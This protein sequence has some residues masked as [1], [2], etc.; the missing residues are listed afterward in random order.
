MTAWC[1]GRWWCRDCLAHFRGGMGMAQR[2]SAW[3]PR[4]KPPSWTASL[5][6]YRPSRRSCSFYSGWENVQQNTATPAGKLHAGF[7]SKKTN[8]ILPN[9]S[10][11]DG[12]KC[13]R[14]EKGRIRK[15]GEEKKK[16]RGEVL[17]LFP[18]AFSVNLRLPHHKQEFLSQWDNLNDNVI[19]HFV[20]KVIYPFSQT[21]VWGTKVIG[22]TD[23]FTESGWW[24]EPFRCAAI[25]YYQ[26]EKVKIFPFKG[27]NQA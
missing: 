16:G 13:K 6:N 2:F 9:T 1:K 7:T 11:R 15:K 21:E 20:H 12:I 19:R 26:Q 18:K 17:A 5:R 14:K 4:D 24:H 3:P 22:S 23:E 25:P 27:L 10:S 8:T